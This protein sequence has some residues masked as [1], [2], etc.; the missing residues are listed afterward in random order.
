MRV[1]RGLT[2]ARLGL[3]LALLASPGA[4]PA[5][6]ASSQ[7]A[8]A[9]APDSLYR[10]ALPSILTLRVVRNDGTNVTG[11]AFIALREGL[12]LTAFHVIRDAAVVTA[13]SAS[14]EE[15]DVT[16]VIDSDARRDIALLKV[17][18]FGLPLLPT[19][20]EEP[21]VGAR[22]YVIGAPQGLEFSLSEGLVSQI[23]VIEGKKLLQFTC[24]ASPGNSGGP[25]MGG[26]G[27]VLGIVSSQLRDGQ[28]LN[29]AVPIAAALAL[30]PN[31]PVTPWNGSG[32]RSPFVAATTI[33]NGPLDRLL[34]TT[35]MT[36]LET[37]AIW[38]ATIEGTV[39]KSLG[40][41]AGVPAVMYRQFEVL[42]QARAQTAAAE[43]EDPIR[44]RAL[45]QMRDCLAIQ[46]DALEL[47]AS[48]IR[49]AESASTWRGL[50][51]D[52]FN[53]AVAKRSTGPV[54]DSTTWAPLLAD[55]LALT[56][57]PLAVRVVNH[58]SPDPYGFTL[59]VRVWPSNTLRLISVTDK[60]LAD[61]FG[62]SPGDEIVN[63]AGTPVRDLLDVKAIVFQARGKK[64]YVT[65]RRRG[66]LM[67]LWNIPIPAE[68]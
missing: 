22:A 65:V 16:G 36:V 44:A 68:L 46:Q 18:A 10:R 64:C 45:A 9:L 62:L 52:L 50:A 3:L 37:D 63:V 28:N 61:R 55:S 15:F 49:A 58:L 21:A 33:A 31:L 51:Q 43:T 42:K 60:S 29:F 19:P 26:S 13:R 8:R 27:Q 40:F 57:V 24:A 38:A 5:A 30:D 39:R 35:L 41:N 47:L 66:D 17:K 56:E 2:A 53:R 20:S 23:Q 48:A 54:P 25:L 11:T 59:G 67:K 12:A 34:R 1:I 6:A 14:G 7:S 32:Q 4:G